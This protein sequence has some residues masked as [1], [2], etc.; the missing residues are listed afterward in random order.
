[1]NLIKAI[2]ASLMLISCAYASD[3]TDRVY[4]D[5][6]ELEIGEDCFYIHTG[7][8]MWIKTQALTRDA[9]GLYIMETMSEL[10]CPNEAGYVRHW[11]C[12]YCN[13]Y[14]EE[15]KPCTNPKCPRLYKRK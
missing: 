5:E 12:P 15:G 9:T 1:M 2:L 10:D 13:Y 4:I 8:N 11:K 3:T 6:K 14:W 7:E